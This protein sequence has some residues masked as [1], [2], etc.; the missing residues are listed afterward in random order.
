[1]WKFV[2]YVGRKSQTTSKVKMSRKG[3]YEKTGYGDRWVN[4]WQPYE[5]V[6]ICE[7]CAERLFSIKTNKTKVN[8][9]AK[10]I[11]DKWKGG[12]HGK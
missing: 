12:S 6:V 4:L 1:M 2:T 5:R 10:E 8:E 9:I 11:E 7:N 3:Y